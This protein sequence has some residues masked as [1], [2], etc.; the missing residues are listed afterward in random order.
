M[1]MDWTSFLLGQW[2]GVAC[3]ALGWYVAAYQRR[4]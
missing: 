1:M 2:F 3:V 4:K